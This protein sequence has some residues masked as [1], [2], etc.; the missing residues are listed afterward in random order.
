MNVHYF[1]FTSLPDL[2]IRK[3]YTRKQYEIITKLLVSI[4]RSF[5]E[6]RAKAEEENEDEEA[7]ENMPKKDLTVITEEDLVDLQI[8]DDFL[9]AHQRAFDQKKALWHMFI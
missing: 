5:L 7:N 6:Q 2:I 4:K 9:V 8:L 3:Q 1:L